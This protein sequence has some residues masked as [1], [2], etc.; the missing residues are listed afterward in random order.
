MDSKST[1][2]IKQLPLPRYDKSLLV[3]I[4]A[5]L[6]LGLVMVASASVVVSQQA[7][8]TPFHFLFRQMCFLLVALVLAAQLLKVPIQYIARCSPKIFLITLL[9]LCLVL[10]PHLGRNINGSQRWL[11]LGPIG[12]QV[13]ELAKLA[14]I[15]YLSGY[16]VR[17]CEEVKTRMI[18]F[19]K[20][21]MVLALVCFL[22]LQEPDFG[23]SVVI[24]LTV[25]GLLFLAEIPLKY[26][27]G[28]IV[29]I[30]T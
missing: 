15:L 17:R 24:I 29:V 8:G 26:F 30:A 6:T 22:L 19:I 7:F 9:L 18:G 5:I 14:T 23:A 27:I 20:P 3:V 10:I 2:T 13:S 4:F 28:L 25:M 12:L 21:M 1:P 16:L 11:N